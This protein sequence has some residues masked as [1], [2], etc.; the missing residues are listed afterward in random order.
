[1]D[2]TSHLSDSPRS[3]QYHRERIFFG[4][5]KSDEYLGTLDVYAGGFPNF[6]NRGGIR[7]VA[8]VTGKL[9]LLSGARTG[10][11]EITSLMTE[12]GRD[13]DNTSDWR[14][15]SG[16]AVLFNNRVIGVVTVRASDHKYDF[17][18]TRVD[19]LLDI[20]DFRSSI[21]DGVEAD[22]P[23]RQ[24]IYARSPINDWQ[25]LSIAYLDTLP[26]L[27]AEEAI[28][29]FDGALP[30]WRHAVSNR[31][32]R[33]KIV[34]ALVERVVSTVSESN[35]CI[36]QLII[37]AAGEGKTTVLLQTA[38][39]LLHHGYNILWRSNTHVTIDLD[40]LCALDPKSVW[41]IIA[42]RADDLISNID[43]LSGRLHELGR[44]NVV[45]VLACRDTD[46][47]FAGGFERDWENRLRVLPEIVLRG[48]DEDDAA[49]IVGA[50]SVGGDAGMRSLAKYPTE[51]EQIMALVSATRKV[52]GG[53]SD[54]SFYGGLLEIRFDEESFRSHV[55]EMMKRL[56]NIT[57]FNQSTLLNALVFVAMTHSIR[58][59]GLHERV[60]A[61]LVEASPD[62]V[63]SRV[64]RKLGEEAA[65][66]E[67]SSH[68]FTRHRRV[69]SIIVREAEE[70]FGIDL[71]E[72]WRLL[73][74]AT[75]NLQS[76]VDPADQ[77]YRRTVHAGPRFERELLSLPRNRRREIA[78]SVAQISREM[79]P[80]RLDCLVDLA[81]VFRLAKRG[82]EAILLFR[83]SVYNINDMIDYAESVRG[84]WY[85]WGVCEGYRGRDVGADT[86]LQSISLSDRFEAASFTTERIA[87]SCAGLGKSFARNSHEKE[88][89]KALSAVSYIGLLVDPDPNTKLYLENHAIEAKRAGVERPTD[90]FYAIEWLK[91]GARKAYS[92]LR[93]PFIK[94]LIAASDFEYSDLLEFIS[95]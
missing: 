37:A 81:T 32:P 89:A 36:L 13:V 54:G 2:P 71:L 91:D 40:Q 20:P 76:Q 3:S 69:A 88:F 22:D 29:Y 73:I 53:R 77:S 10:L 80:T 70:R 23:R 86:C 41:V 5:G 35:G 17:G 79:L 15:F 45:L 7:E 39:D 19:D 50:W 18:A 68:V 47:R 93:D 59:P 48:L 85:E 4:L 28:R 90:T 58:I 92:L 57:I 51:S 30:T 64:V 12:G 9:P 74:R 24:S 67:T 87:I 27:S 95:K 6:L 38:I 78:L 16:S 49:Q 8:Q 62:W 42:D 44:S 72:L 31:I 33:L 43:E 11:F 66:G 65:V 55:R 56:S 25:M 82:D 1:M 94:Q 21:L 60:L 14:G 63:R 46:W 34:H 26:Q 52:E 84:F 75:I 83:K 61:F